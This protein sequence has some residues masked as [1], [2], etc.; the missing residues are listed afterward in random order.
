MSVQMSTP[1]PNRVSVT[2]N[3]TFCDLFIAS[4][5]LI[6]YQFALMIVYAI[7]PLAGLFMLVFPLYVGN[8]LGLLPVIGALFAF[9]F[10]P[11]IMALAVWSAR[12]RNKLTQGPFTYS[13]DSEGM[14]ISGGTFNL[15]IKW[16]AIPRV[17]QS[18]HFLF[19]FTAP[20]RAQAIPL[21]ALID[22]GALDKVRS[23]AGQ[24]T[25]LR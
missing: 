6:R 16:S 2:I 22:Q 21:K 25:D 1:V 7:F 17:R 3:P 18:K 19:V 11:I 20:A 24:H 13:F 10:I 23:I 9:S 15:T 5:A 14:Q 8:R 4:F 12:R